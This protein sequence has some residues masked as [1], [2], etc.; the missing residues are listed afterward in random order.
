MTTT[1]LSREDAFQ[2]IRDAEPRIRGLGVRRLALFG[3][4]LRDEAGADSDVDLLVQF[5]P[6]QKTAAR[7]FALYDLLEELLPARVELVTTEA[8]SP[9]IGPRILAE[10]TDVIPAV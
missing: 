8:L 6:G 3:S 2:L 4:V 7:F 5:E 10:A 9:F 1:I